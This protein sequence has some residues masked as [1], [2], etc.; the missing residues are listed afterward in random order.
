MSVFYTIACRVGRNCPVNVL[1]LILNQSQLWSEHLIALTIIA[2][3]Y[4]RSDYALRTQ[5]T[6]RRSEVRRIIV[7]SFSKSKLFMRSDGEIGRCQVGVP[8]RC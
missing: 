4:D 6:W 2:R 1:E 7:G 5:K 3:C 8:L